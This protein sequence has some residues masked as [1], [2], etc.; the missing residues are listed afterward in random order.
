MGFK[1]CLHWSVI[2]MCSGIVSL[3]LIDRGICGS[4]LPLDKET[5]FCIYYKMSG[6][7]MGQQDLEELCLN[8]GMPTFTAYKPSEMFTKN[9]L[10]GLKHKLTE[11]MKALSGNSMF[12]W[13]LT[14]TLAPNNS[15]I[16]GHSFT[17][18]NDD[19][20]KATVFIGS[21]M[22]KRGKRFINKLLHSLVH[23]S[24]S[25]AE[26]MAVNINVY[27]RP[28]KIFYRFKNRNI[29]RQDIYLPHRS[30]IFRP[31][32]IE[33]CSEKNPDRVL[34]ARDIP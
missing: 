6:E 3:L 20:P 9:T 12:R 13:S 8:L 5:V 28:E 14:R 24:S 31:V 22:T 26:Q 7:D 11:K 17:L 33:V 25:H 4:P 16:Y 23:A 34:L 10:R 15:G 18:V 1:T 29:A 30:V 19:M 32:K 21:E 2:V 27:L